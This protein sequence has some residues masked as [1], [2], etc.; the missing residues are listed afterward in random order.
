VVSASS[1]K[2]TATLSKCAAAVDTIQNLDLF[3]TRT[4]MA[5]CFVYVRCL[6]PKM[7][8]VI[9]FKE[10]YMAQPINMEEKSQ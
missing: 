4:W 1:A 7:R 2:V 8:D 10:L 5:T 3:P 6:C 9:F